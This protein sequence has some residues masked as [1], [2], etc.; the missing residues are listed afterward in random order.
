MIRNDDFLNL[1]GLGTVINGDNVVGFSDPKHKIIPEGWADKANSHLYESREDKKGGRNEIKKHGHYLGLIEL[2]ATSTIVQRTMGADMLKSDAV[3]ELDD[4]NEEITHDIAVPSSETENFTVVA[5]SVDQ[6]DGGVIGVDGSPFYVY[7]DKAPTAGDVFKPD[8]ESPYQANVVDNIGSVVKEGDKY[9]V[10]LEY[11]TNSSK[12]DFPKETLRAGNVWYKVAHPIAENGQQYST[13]TSLG[14]EPGY[15]EM[16]WKLGDPHGV[17]SA[18]TQDAGNRATYGATE[19]AKQ[20]TAKLQN[21]LLKVTGNRPN[22]TLF[23]SG[24]FNH[25]DGVMG[26]TRISNAMEILTMAETYKIE[27]M[28]NMFATAASIKDSNGGSRRIIEGAWLQARRGKIIPYPRPNALSVNHL[29]EAAHYYFKNSDLPINER[30]ITFIGGSGAT[31]QGE[32][33]LNQYAQSQLDRLPVSIIGTQGLLKGSQIISGPANAMVLNEV[34][35]R[36]AFIPMLGWTS[37]KHDPSFDWKSFE[38]GNATRDGFLGLGGFN[39][40]SYT[41]MIDGM[42]TSSNVVNRLKGATLVENGNRTANLYYVKPK[43]EHI[44]WGYEQ[45]RMN[46]GYQTSGIVSSLRH[47][48]QTFWT[49]IRS[50]MLMTD[51]TRNVIIELDNMYAK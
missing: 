18:W 14:A 11:Y 2:M 36:E 27:A 22:K 12:K 45:G 10:T 19:I 40:L 20:T 26:T 24:R 34:K 5:D 46:N 32:L 23:V 39:K 33:I 6:N 16:V 1:Y 7:F 51:V 50:G 49:Q 9:K 25:K 43:L 21:T 47:R 44:I 41:L 30:H 48:G 13:V 8:L 42:S 4:A 28:S 15:L 38:S 29:V 31:Q 3:I 17:E 35:Y 37:F